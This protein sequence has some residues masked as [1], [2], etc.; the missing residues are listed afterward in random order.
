VRELEPARGLPP[1]RGL[2]AVAL[3]GL[4][5]SDDRLRALQSGFQ[6]HLAKP[7]DPQELVSTLA[8]LAGRAGGLPPAAAVAPQAPAPLG[9]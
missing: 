7:V 1:G 5:R 6:V 4:A 8:M 3:T 2:P 9:R